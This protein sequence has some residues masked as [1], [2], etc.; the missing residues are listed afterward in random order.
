M[1]P[2]WSIVQNWWKA[3][4]CVFV[5]CVFGVLQQKI[6]ITEQLKHF[7]PTSAWVRRRRCYPCVGRLLGGWAMI[8]QLGEAQ[9][10]F[11]STIFPQTLKRTRLGHVPN[12][13]TRQGMLKYI[14][15]TYFPSTISPHNF[16]STI[17]P[18]TLKRTSGR[19]RLHH[20]P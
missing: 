2:L 16:H 7:P 20:F 8:Q 12:K 14:F 19:F 13:S 3:D 11:P 4:G 15:Q 1:K 6:G 10:G 5:F 9:N 18:Q 17:F